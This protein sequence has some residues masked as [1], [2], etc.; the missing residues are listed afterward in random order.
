MMAIQANT[1]IGKRPLEREAN[2]MCEPRRFQE[3]S[4]IMIYFMHL[5]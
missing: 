5:D 4:F 1:E 3:T 2:M